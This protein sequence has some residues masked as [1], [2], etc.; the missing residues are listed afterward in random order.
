MTIE[1]LQTIRDFVEGRIGTPIFAAQFFANER[2]KAILT[3]DPGL[4]GHIHDGKSV[5]DVLLFLNFAD[6]R[7]I[8][9]AQWALTLYYRYDVTP[10]CWHISS[11]GHSEQRGLVPVQMCLP[12]GTS[13]RLSSIQLS[14]G[15]RASSFARVRSG[16][17]AAT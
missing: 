3:D 6:P 4:P 5:Y 11:S 13:S 10:T 2:F 9:R 1:E 17:D 8:A 14:R 12:N 7:G 16:V 15:T